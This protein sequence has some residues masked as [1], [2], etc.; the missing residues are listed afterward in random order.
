MA[1]NSTS[2]AK[3]AETTRNFLWFY[4]NGY[5]D[6]N[7]FLKGLFLLYFYSSFLVIEAL[8]GPSDNQV[9]S[10]SNLVSSQ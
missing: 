10:T 9:Y 1:D 3:F 4:E 2:I 5:I 7:T 8:P 6:R